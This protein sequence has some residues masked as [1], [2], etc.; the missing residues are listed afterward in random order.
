MSKSAAEEKV[1]TE[2]VTEKGGCP[3]SRAA[4]FS[5]FFGYEMIKFIHEQREKRQ[6]NV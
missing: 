2:Y 6:N 5:S 4:L 3:I 1:S